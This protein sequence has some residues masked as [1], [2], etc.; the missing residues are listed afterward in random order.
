MGFCGEGEKVRVAEE[1]VQTQDKQGGKS[2][3]AVAVQDDARRK[4]RRRRI[5]AL[6]SFLLRTISL[7][8]VVYILVFHV[9]GLTVM[10]SGDMTP[11][12]DAG[13]LLLFYRIDKTAKSRD[14]VVV[15]KAINKDNSANESPAKEDPGFIRKA[16]NWL[17]FKDPDAPPTQRFVCRVVACPGDTVNITEEGG[18]SVNGNTLIEDFIYSPTRP[19]EGYVEYPVV[20][21]P[22]EYFVL[23]DSRNGGVDSRYFGPVGLEEIQGIVITILRRNNL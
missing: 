1:P 12:L 10:P 2:G 16:L 9:I 18:L 7:A 23:S 15:D 20:L 22:E 11:R 8:L 14:I 17:G 13:D 21:G 6:R 19:Y 4:R 3:E 5:R